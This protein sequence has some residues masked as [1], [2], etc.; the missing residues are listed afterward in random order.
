MDKPKLAKLT[1]HHTVPHDSVLI[2]DPF[3]TQLITD[4]Q[5]TRFSCKT[6]DCTTPI[7]YPSTSEAIYL[8]LGSLVYTSTQVVIRP[9]YCG[10]TVHG[11]GKLGTHMQMTV[12]LSLLA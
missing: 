10:P 3:T 6:N 2:D 7:D 11:A 1:Q 9:N 12:V 8:H 5:H 4:S